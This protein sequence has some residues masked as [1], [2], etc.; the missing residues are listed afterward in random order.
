MLALDDPDNSERVADWLE[1][2]LS[3]GEASFSKSKLSSVVRDA[4]GI[5]PSEAFISD[6]WRHLRG[7]IALYSSDFFEIHGDLVNCSK[8]V[9]E[10]KLEYQVCLFFSLYGASVQQ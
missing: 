7:R 3:L 6:V 5:E 4:T 8:D 10:G 9:V 2:E 1:L